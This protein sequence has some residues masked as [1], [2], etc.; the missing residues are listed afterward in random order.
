MANNELKG[1]SDQE[2]KDKI[3]DEKSTLNKQKLNHAISPIENPSKI[4]INRRNIARLLTE[5]TSR[6]KASK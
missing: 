5:G 6:K 1:L 3:A 2:L 4:R